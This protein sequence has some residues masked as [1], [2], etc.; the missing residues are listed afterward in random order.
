MWQIQIYVQYIT[1]EVSYQIIYTRNCVGVVVAYS[2]VNRLVKIFLVKLISST[3]YWK[4][5]S[6]I[7][8]RAT[9]HTVRRWVGEA[10]EGAG[11]T[12]P[13]LIL[14]GCKLDLVEVKLGH[15]L[16]LYQLSDWCEERG[17]QGG[18]SGLGRCTWRPFYWDLGQAGWLGLSCYIEVEWIKTLFIKYL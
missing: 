6:L 7:Y 15:F 2:L 12:S 8:F 10:R 9:F 5:F 11:P 13:S 18:R 16:L 17:G 1:V 3:K 4:Y 14:I